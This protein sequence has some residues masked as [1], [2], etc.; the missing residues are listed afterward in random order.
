MALLKTG[1]PAM[2]TFL[3]SLATKLLTQKFITKVFILL[4]E[5]LSKRTDNKI[6]DELV[7]AIKE[8]IK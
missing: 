6:D 5:F 2:S 4:A 7:G 1:A 3:T 8:A